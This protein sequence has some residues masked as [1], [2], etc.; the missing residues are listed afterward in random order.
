[1]I[2]TLTV[3]STTHFIIGGQSFQLIFLVNEH[4]QQLHTISAGVNTNLT[5]PRIDT[6]YERITH[7]VERLL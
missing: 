7:T 4:F 3:V 2:W 1:M 5:P 6:H